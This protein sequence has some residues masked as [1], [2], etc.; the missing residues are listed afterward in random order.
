MIYEN[1]EKF[2]DGCLWGAVSA[3]YQVEG[4]WNQDVN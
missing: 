3:A 1:L 2:S 4:A